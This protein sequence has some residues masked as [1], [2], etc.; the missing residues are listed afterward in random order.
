MTEDENPAFPRRSPAR[1]PQAPAPRTFTPGLSVLHIGK[2]YPPYRG[3]I[4]NHL[5][6]LCRELRKS[7]AVRV[8]VAN[9][10]PR[11]VESEVDGVSVKRL[12]RLFSLSAAPVCP[13]LTRE[14]RTSNADLVHLHLPNPP[15]MLACLASG[16]SRPL[17]V[18]WHSDIV[19]QRVLSPLLR[20]FERMLASRSSA[21]IATSPKYADT[22]P[23][24][25]RYRGRCHIIPHGI[26][27]RDFQ[28]PRRRAHR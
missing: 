5:Q 8:V 25:S 11:A 4:E 15:A 14:I 19:R 23:V 7:I 9:D 26:P 12:A 24:L 3:G 21:L 27:N 17:V 1:P 2:F 6:V 16:D 22:S 13:R 18:T 20:P 10:G 28:T